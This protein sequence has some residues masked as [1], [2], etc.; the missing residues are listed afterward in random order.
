MPT[1]LSN[2][3]VELSVKYNGM[4]VGEVTHTHL[5]HSCIQFLRQ[6]FLT[7][8]LVPD[9]VPTAKDVQVNKNCKDACPQGVCSR[10]G[11]S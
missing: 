10:R 6:V 4:D 9:M 5:L 1:R 11:Y 2:A 7:S 3:Q 8:C